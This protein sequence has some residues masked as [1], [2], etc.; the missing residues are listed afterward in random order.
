MDIYIIQVLT[1]ISS[2]AV[3]FMV[4]SG[5]TL[6]FGA[7]RIVNFAHGSLYMVGAFVS[8]SIGNVVGVTNATFVLVLLGSA[9]AVG[10]VGMLLEV[11]ALR[12]I[13]RQPVLVQLTATFAFV[14]M[15][16]AIV[17]AVY[18]PSPRLAPTPPFLR[19]GIEILGHGYPVYQIF[20]VGLA[21]AVAVALWAIVYKSGLGRMIRAAVDDPELLRMTGVDVGRLFT[22]VFILGSLFAGLGGAANAPLGSINLGMDVDVILK[23]FVIVVIGGMGSLLGAFMAAMLVGVAEAVGVLVLPEASLAVVFLVLVAVLAVRPSG[24]FGKSA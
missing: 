10:V 6:I 15:I 2:G 22:G 20:L 3:L 5:L 21:I 4:A 16:G 9:V 11:S 8:V 7:L 23:A 17:R 18:G 24:M 12:L 14:L 19:G 13:Y 1:G